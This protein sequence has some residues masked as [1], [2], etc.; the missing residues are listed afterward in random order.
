MLCDVDTMIVRSLQDCV[1]SRPRTPE[2]TWNA[3]MLSGLVIT[4]AQAWRKQGELRRA[5]EHYRYSC[6]GSLEFQVD[7]LETVNGTEQVTPARTEELAQ[8]RTEL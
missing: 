1:I 7:L 2:T 4:M 5:D 6:E 8:A 3:Q